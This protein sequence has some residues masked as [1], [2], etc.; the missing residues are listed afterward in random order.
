MA[1]SVAKL[2][3]ITH[4]IHPNEKCFLLAEL[5]LT[6]FQLT[7]GGKKYQ[8]ENFHGRQRWRIT[9]VNRGDKLAEYHEMSPHQDV[10]PVRIP[11]FWEHTYG[12]LCGLA[13]D[14]ATGQRGAESDRALL[15]EM[16]AESTLVQDFLDQCEDRFAMLNNVSTFGPVFKKQR[17][18]FPDILREKAEGELHRGY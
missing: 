11:S 12:E 17:D 18:G 8:P 15:H 13:D 9:W 3:P 10:P 4:F 7:R 1:Q 16:R 6:P 2:T 14:Y 5:Y